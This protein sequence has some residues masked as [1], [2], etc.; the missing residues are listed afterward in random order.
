MLKKSET[1]F[2]ERHAGARRRFAAA[3]NK[4]RLALRRARSMKSTGLVGP[5]VYFWSKKSVIF[6]ELYCCIHKLHYFSG[7]TK[8]NKPWRC[9]VAKLTLEQKA[10]IIEKPLEADARGDYDEGSRLLRQLPIAPWLAKAGK[11]V[12]GKEFLLENE[13]DL[14]EAEA[15]YGKDWLSR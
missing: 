3:A 8:I 13:Y 5:L 12:W 2:S 6:I 11:E 15:A 4:L 14:S 7:P 1:T 10:E 9:M